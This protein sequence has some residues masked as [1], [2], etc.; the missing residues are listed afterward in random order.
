[1]LAVF[2]FA[3]QLVGFF[4]GK[5]MVCATYGVLNDQVEWP[6]YVPAYILEYGL[7]GVVL[8]TLYIDSGYGLFRHYHCQLC[9][10]GL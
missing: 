3:P 5:G 10:F 6:P 1:M 9:S 2:F 8:T 4:K 7:W